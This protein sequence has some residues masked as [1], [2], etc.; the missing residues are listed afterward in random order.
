M[1]CVVWF[2]L[3]HPSRIWVLGHACDCLLVQ[4][5]PT[6]VTIRAHEHEVLEPSRDKSITPNSSCLGVVLCVWFAKVLHTSMQRFEML[7]LAASSLRKELE[8][9]MCQH[10]HNSPRIM[11]SSTPSTLKSPLAANQ[12]KKCDPDNAIKLPST[13]VPHGLS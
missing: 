8:S 12:L 5:C 7:P 10:W 9:A 3:F 4:W 6:R 11:Y 13:E 1:I 2:S